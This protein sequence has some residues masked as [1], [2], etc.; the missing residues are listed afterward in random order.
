MKLLTALAILLQASAGSSDPASHCPVLPPQSDVTWT[1]QQGPDFGV[2]YA[3]D[4]ATHK[5]AFGVYLGFAPS[6]RP[7]PAKPHTAG[8][9]GGHP[10]QW[11]RQDPSSNPSE[12]SREAL[13]NLDR[14]SIAHVWVTASSE[15]QL[16]QRLAVLSKLQ[17]H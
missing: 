12:F 9:I 15:Q 5:D 6:F 13:V 14:N 16:A 8:V 10:V 7:D 4:S 11:Y 2:C 3:V 1:Y 17:F